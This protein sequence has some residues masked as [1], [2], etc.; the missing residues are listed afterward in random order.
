[1]SWTRT[2]G[3]RT[4]S[5]CSNKARRFIRASTHRAGRQA[6]VSV[7][8]K[9]VRGASNFAALKHCPPFL[10]CRLHCSATPPGQRSLVQEGAPYG[11]RTNSRGSNRVRQFIRASTQRSGRQPSV[12]NEEKM[13][14]RKQ[15]IALKQCSAKFLIWYYGSAALNANFLGGECSDFF[16]NRCEV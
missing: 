12:S 16:V 15:I 8:E 3:G 7:E 13:D 11:W 4:N 1:M 9:N 2:L 14:E 5:R 6:S 10:R